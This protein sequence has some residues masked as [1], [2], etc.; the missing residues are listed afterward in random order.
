MD[1]HGNSFGVGQQTKIVHQ[2][3]NV[4][5]VRFGS[6]FN[7]VSDALEANTIVD[8]QLFDFDTSSPTN[9]RWVSMRG[10]SL[11]NTMTPDASTPPL[12]DG[13]L[14]VDGM[15]IYT[16]FIDINGT[17]GTL[18]ILPVIGGGTTTA[19]LAGTCG[20][21]PELPYTNLIVDLYVADTTAAAPPEG[22][23]WLASFRDNSAADADTNVGSF[24]FALPSGLVASG[25]KV[26]I[27]VTYSSDTGPTIRSI[28]R[29][30]G[31]TTLAVTGGTGPIYGIVQASAVTGPYTHIA[32]QTGAATTFT[33]GATPQSFYRATGA[34]ATGQ[35]SPFSALFTM[36]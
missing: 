27:T 10:N 2:F 3:D 20:K 21:L 12:G 15:N 23:I 6:D 34:S 32:A 9:T 29:A 13:Q 22:K 11:V 8:S 18:A 35:T 33:D 36:P 19:F 7:G 17:N 4:S 30:G 26:T 25:T 24:K 16:N 28:S 31:Q 5:T 1:I 14:D